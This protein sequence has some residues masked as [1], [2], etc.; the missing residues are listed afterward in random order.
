M[1]HG[2]LQLRYLHFS[3]HSSSFWVEIENY[4]QK[5]SFFGCLEVPLKFLWDYIPSNLLAGRVEWLEFD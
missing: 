1:F 3:L 4:I 5:I 2:Q